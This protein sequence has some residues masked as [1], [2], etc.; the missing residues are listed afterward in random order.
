MLQSHR[1]LLP[2]IDRTIAEEQAR[3]KPDQPP[4]QR[5]PSTSRGG[6][7]AK[8]RN[9]SQKP[10]PD[11]PIDA[12]AN[13]DPAVFEAAFILDDGEEAS[14]AST[15]KPP[16]MAA[17][18]KAEGVEEPGAPPQQSNGD[19]EKDKSDG[20]GQADAPQELSP[21]IRS[22]LRKLEKLEKTYPE[23][24]R[25][26]RIA[27]SRATSIEPFE[28]ALKEHTSV[29]SIKEPEALVEYLDSLKQKEQLI[30]E[31]YKKVSIE[32]DEMK[33]KHQA[34]ERELAELKDEVATL[35]ANS[36]TTDGPAKPQPESKE[37]DAASDPTSNPSSVKS[38]VQSVLGIFSPKQKPQALED[39]K[40]V[41]TDG[42][43]LFS[44]DDEVPQM[45]ADVHAKTEEIERLNAEVTSLKQELA[46]AKESSSE[47]VQ[48]LEKST[49]EA[50]ELRDSAAATATLKTQLEAR[51]S[52]ISSLDKKLKATQAQL[53]ETKT[54]LSKELDSLR[55]SSKE[56]QTKATEAVKR[57]DKEHAEVEKLNKVKT[58]SE[59]KIKNL[60]ESIDDL[61]KLKA[62]DEAKIAELT[63]K[64][65]QAAQLTAKAPSPATPAAPAAPTAVPAAAPTTA[66]AAS[67]KKN[68]KK[69]KGGAAAGSAAIESISE[70]VSET[71]E[72]TAAVAA[73]AED[74]SF[75]SAELEAEIARLKDEVT[76]RDAQIERLS[77]QRKTEED[78]TEEI[79]TLRDEL[80][81]IGQGHV[82]SKQ[83]IKELEEEKATLQARIEE[84]EREIGS[85]THDAE[86]QVKL[87][88]EFDGL[89]K[90][91]AEQLAQTRYKD[92]TDLR[93]VLQKAQP[94]MKALRQDSAALKTTKEE[95]ATKISELRNVEKREKD[96]KTE[97]A[98][99]QRF[100]TE[101]ESDIKSLR[102]KLNA[103]STSR[104]RLED[105]QRVAGR[106]LRRSEAE[107]AEISA[108]EEK[109]TR[110]LQAIKAEANKL[111]PRVKELEEE[112]EKLHLLGSMRD[113]TAELSTQLKESRSQ[114]EALEEELAEIQKHLSERSREAERMRGML[115]DVDGRADSKVREM[116]SRMEAAI[117]E[118]DRIEDESSTLARRKSRETEE[119]K[120][121]I[122]ELEREV[123][124]LAI[125]KDE[126]ET[127]ERDW[128]RRREEL[129]GVEEKTEA[130][131]TE[132]RSAVSDLQSA[133][134][135]SEQQVREAEK[136]KTD[137]RRLLEESR[138]RFEK[139]SKDLK[140]AQTKL[141][142]SLSSE[143]SSMDSSRSGANGAAGP[144]SADNMYLKTILLQ[145]LE[146][147]DNRLREQLVPV[148][149]RILQFN[150]TDEKKWRDAIQHIN[151]R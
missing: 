89:R 52:E 44:Y 133:L 57:A 116:R 80:T 37:P 20:A 114:S 74:P 58:E 8:Q 38:P 146:Q 120:Q 17:D 32:K 143:R 99:A 18:E 113:Q 149:G 96:A 55:A 150:K 119:Q 54:S 7:S 61:K 53:E 87:Q 10:V 2:S 107:K 121:K 76:Q 56:S 27:H 29:T 100:T 128:R 9:R 134:D 94:E 71:T 86:A 28:R 91:A 51:D 24:L 4:V 135:A 108:R 16:G 49:R 109:A 6:G 72:P 79:E 14:R 34:T 104:I 65:A 11:L 47:L 19:K 122:R 95:L 125:E 144:G 145:F 126:L 75:S 36:H 33:K 142:A 12:P 102:E 88:S 93:E 73:A 92:L 40:P 50:G 97:L 124:S 136:Q 48:N 129:E 84:L 105:A 67:K 23:L 131:L 39:D 90:D 127:R 132:M 140:T 130:E 70:P 30:M 68:K 59:K 123:K 98:K 112:V 15:P 46:V 83:R 151:V 66:S 147:K 3:Q 60:T 111:R 26:Y 78:L 106:D 101:R 31:E 22:K 77:K 148:L 5:T 139:V 82:E 115:A 13:P 110:E 63:K 103:E 41:E 118:R 43:D 45:Q 64:H 69:K 1:C 81:D 138:Q 141:G 137:L 85:A 117:E 35:K 25:S 21:E 42:G 62:Q